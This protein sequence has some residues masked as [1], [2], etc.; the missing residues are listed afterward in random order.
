VRQTGTLEYALPESGQ[1]RLSVYDVLGRE[2]A[3]L[4]NQEQ[5]AGRKQVDI[6]AS[7]WSSGTYFYRLEAG[8]ATKT[9]RFTVV[10]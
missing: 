9:Q 5:Q 7:Q 4:V 2:V 6:N 1:V 3:V 10:H 8:S